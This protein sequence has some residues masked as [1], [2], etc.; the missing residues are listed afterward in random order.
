MFKTLLR[1]L[2]ASTLLLLAAPLP[3]SAQMT[4]AQR[5]E[6]EAVVKDYL[7][8]NPEI[9]RDAFVEL[10]RRQKAEEE[11]A[12]VKAITELSG[13]IFNAPKQAV[14]GNPNGKV[15]LVEFFDYNCGYC[16]R[17]LDDIATLIKE[18]KDLRFVL[19]D[20]PVLGPGSVE[21][22]EVAIA[23]LNQASGDKYWQFH[24]KLL[25][26]R[27]QVGKA[28]ALGVAKEVGADMDRLTKD[29][30]SPQSRAVLQDIMKI[31][32]RLQ[33]TGTPTFVL[34]DEVIV[35]AVGRD[36][37]KERIA[38]VRKCGKTACS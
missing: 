33:L 8:K 31:A 15:T 30:A 6:V 25:G 24:S 11:Q 19:K 9:L 18:D 37:L 21:A 22:A 10:E 26:T 35:G 16:K 34:A 1:A 36:Q 14:I 32:D 28:Q 23:M 20:F 38:N 2:A 3:V 12:R 7:L 5:G 17:A 29:M 4:P 13:L 27:G